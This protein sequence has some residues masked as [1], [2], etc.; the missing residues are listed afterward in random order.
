MIYLRI[1]WSPSVVGLL[2]DLRYLSI[3]VDGDGSLAK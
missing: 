2:P 1:I 3:P